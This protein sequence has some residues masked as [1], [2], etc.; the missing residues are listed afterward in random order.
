MVLDLDLI[1][2]PYVLYA[3]ECIVPVSPA[4]FSAYTLVGCAALKKGARDTGSYV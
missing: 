1:R 4:P 3:V 2:A